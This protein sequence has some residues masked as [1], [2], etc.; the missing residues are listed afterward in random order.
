M[1]SQISELKELSG[2][3]YKLFKSH[4]MLYIREAALVTCV[5]NKELGLLKRVNVYLIK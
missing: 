1:E 3:F 2:F 5:A 4:K